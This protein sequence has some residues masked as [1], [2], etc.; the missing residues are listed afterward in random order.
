MVGS[1]C[2]GPGQVALLR[3]KAHVAA[4]RFCFRNSHTHLAS[5]PLQPV[6]CHLWVLERCDCRCCGVIL[7][8]VDLPRA[9][10]MHCSLI[11]LCEHL[12][13]VRMSS[14][15]QLQVPSES[16][17]LAGDSSGRART[18]TLD[19][20]AYKHTRAPCGFLQPETYCILVAESPLPVCVRLRSPYCAHPAVAVG[21]CA[22]PKRPSKQSIDFWC[23]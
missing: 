8:G 7:S 2:H 1:P 19:V 3:W 15:T 18:C 16:R 20:S 13:T 22:R 9:T 6:L 11:V 17:C 4:R 5:K 23:R 21:A 12:M 10:V 14:A